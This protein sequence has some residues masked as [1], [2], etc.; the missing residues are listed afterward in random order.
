MKKSSRRPV[1]FRSDSESRTSLSSL[2]PSGVSSK[3]QVKIIASGKPMMIKTAT[4]RGAQPGRLRMSVRIAASWISSHA[5]M[6]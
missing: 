3:A 4:N 2:M 6:A 5:V 1:S